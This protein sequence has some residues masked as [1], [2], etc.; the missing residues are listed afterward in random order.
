MRRILLFLVI[1]FNLYTSFANYP[2]VRNFRR[3]NYQSGT[4]NWGITQDEMNVMYFANNYGLLEFDGRNWTTFPIG[5]RSNVRSVFY[6][7]DKRI[8]AGASNEFGYYQQMKNGP[9]VY[10]SLV[11]KLKDKDKSFNEVW[12]I[13]QADEDI[14]FQSDR[15]IFR[16]RGDTVLCLPFNN[17]IDVS[18]YISNILFI[19]SAEEGV[20]MV[21]GNLF[22]RVPGSEL[23]ISKKVAAIL[24]Y[25][26]N[27]VLFITSFH[28]VYLFDGKSITPY[29]T[30]IDDFLMSN[31][32]FCATTNGKQI[33]FGT[34]Q[35][36]IAVLNIDDNSVTFVNTYSGLQNN[37]ILSMAFDNQQNLWLGLDKGIDYVQLNNPF[38]N[39][40][41]DNNKYGAGYTSFLKNNTLYLGTNQ[42]L[43]STIY[44]FS[45]GHL[46]MELKLIKGME[47]Q[48]WCLTEID[49]TLFC[50]KD[51]GAYIIHPNSIE[52]I[53][54]LQ[55]TWSFKPLSK[56]PDMIL[57]CSYQGLFILKKTGR[58][59]KLSHFI[60]GNFTETSHIFEEDTDGTV[61]FSQW[62]KGLFHLYFD[63]AYDSIIRVDL[64][65][66]KKG[67]TPNLNNSMF[68]VGGKILFASDQG[69]Y[70][71]NNSTDRV[72]PDT[73]W[74]KMFVSP[75]QHM[76]LHESKYG[77]VWCVSY[78]FAGVAKK[79]SKGEYLMDSLTYCILQPNL[80]LGF[81]NFNFIDSTNII[82]STE[83]G[84]YRLNPLQT[85]FTGDD[86]RV[87]LRNV[88]V[89]NQEHG[90]IETGRIREQNSSG[91]FNHHQNSLRLEFVAPEYRKADLVSYSSKL[92]NYD[93]SWSALSSDIIREYT[94]LPKGNYV[95]KVRAY[96][97][98]RSEMAECEYI[99]NVSPAWYETRLAVSTYVLL[100]IMFC[101]ALII[102]ANYRSKLGALEMEK[103]KEFEIN[104]QKI[105]FEAINTEKKKEI[106]E[107]KNQQ[108]QYVLRH[109]SQ[110]LASSTMNLIRKNEILLQITDK[111]SK[112]TRDLEANTDKNAILS[113]LGQIEKNILENISNDN[114]WK[115]FEENFDMV[116]ENYIKRL[117]ETFPELNISDKKICAYLKMGLSSKDIAS[118]IN[119]SV[120][121]VEMSRYRMRKKIGLDRNTN[122]SEFLQRF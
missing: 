68:R 79:D 56:H 93:E 15:C 71:Y 72:E 106:K 48:V 75:P 101:I 112:V 16:Y 45:D 8:Y 9:L 21:N 46:P 5:N 50:G 76:K 83:D 13:F 107:L 98:L 34:V 39:I 30:G 69:F 41:G 1:S 62:Q 84:F 47:G 11:G 14:Y 120:R 94:H 78:K 122:L 63:S 77:D 40:F 6:A 116:H 73:I 61:W 33:V 121:S 67:F 80:I 86:F 37:T 44:P 66:E 42:G 97:R 36:G 109:K 58:T 104:E 32:V 59:W 57:G 87:F 43:Y 81:E 111:L 64:F 51:Q 54:G 22:I 35:M 91:T 110:E 65:D 90:E 49:N 12:R 23:L 28:G 118:L 25:A 95:F 115:R 74:N 103:Q 2:I 60:K 17:K 119:M 29:K 3:D 114:N 102:W 27:K 18:A 92:E 117:G 52:S 88:V 10:Q 26:D 82:I 108:L 53:K 70:V 4:Q 99:I 24:P 31:Q 38:R 96:N 55:G 113:R 85:V 20:F 19:A 7:S 100:F 89:L 105:Q